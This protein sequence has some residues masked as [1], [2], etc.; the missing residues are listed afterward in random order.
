MV[1]GGLPVVGGGLPVV[2]GGLPVVGGGLPVVG[3]GLP[4]VGFTCRRECS[5]SAA[6]SRLS[7]AWP[8]PG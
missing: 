6:G 2:G 5:R 1:G 3:G 8:P 7:A 4:V